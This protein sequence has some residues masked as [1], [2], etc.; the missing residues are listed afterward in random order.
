MTT[1]PTLYEQCEFV[2]CARPVHVGWVY[3]LSSLSKKT[4]KFNRLQM[5]LQRQAF[6]QSHVKSLN[7]G[8]V[9]VGT[10]PLQKPG[11]YPTELTRQRFFFS[12]PA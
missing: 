6:L 4:R 12:A 11:T 5:S 1:C 8:P 9:G 2:I 10:S 7:I 3:G